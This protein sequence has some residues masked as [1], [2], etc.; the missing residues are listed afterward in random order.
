MPSEVIIADGV[1]DYEVTGVLLEGDVSEVR[2]V[3]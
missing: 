1:G 2:V 3:P